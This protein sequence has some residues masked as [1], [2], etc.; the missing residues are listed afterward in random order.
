M[1]IQ[2]VITNEQE[3]NAIEASKVKSLSAFEKFYSENVIIIQSDGTVF[4]GKDACR[5]GEVGFNSSIITTT[6]KKLLSSVVLP[7]DLPE[8]EFLVV[9]TWYYDLVTSMYPIKGN[10]TSLCYWANDKV[11][12]VIFKSGSEIIA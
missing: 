6:D 10:Q 2:Q 5:A 9:G 3:I 7:S 4:T 11:Q 12:K 8:Y 1:T